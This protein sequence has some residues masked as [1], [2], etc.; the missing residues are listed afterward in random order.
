MTYYVLAKISQIHYKM[1]PAGKVKTFD[2][3]IKANQ[4]QHI[5]VREA[6]KLSTLSCK[7]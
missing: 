7:N 3:K 4:V 5:L 2:Y 6:V 1:T